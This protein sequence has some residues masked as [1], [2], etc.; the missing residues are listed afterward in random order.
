MSDHSLSENEVKSN[1]IALLHLKKPFTGEVYFDLIPLFRGKEDKSRIGVAVGWTL[2]YP[3]NPKKLQKVKV[4]IFNSTKCKHSINK[5]FKFGEDHVCL[6][7]IISNDVGKCW[8]GFGDGSLLV[9]NENEE[10]RLYGIFIANHTESHKYVC[11]TLFYKPLFYTSIYHHRNWIDTNAKLTDEI[12]NDEIYEEEEK[13]V[14][15]PMKKWI[16]IAVVVVG[17]AVAAGVA[18]LIGVTV[19]THFFSK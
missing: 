19:Y 10:N 6:N 17:C 14:K 5:I 18:V 8:G 7:G 1:N 2:E 16:I 3:E 15:K 12:P 11:N 4:T 13:A 9:V